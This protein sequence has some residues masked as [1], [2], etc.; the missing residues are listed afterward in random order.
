MVRFAKRKAKKILM[1]ARSLHSGTVLAF[2][3]ESCHVLTMDPT[4]IATIV[5]VGLSAACAVSAALSARRAASFDVTR[6]FDALVGV[7]AKL[8]KATRSETMSKVRAAALEPKH[9]PENTATAPLTKDQL[10]QL[11][12]ARNGGLTQ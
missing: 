10:R 11:V 6:D 5:L 4:L 7:V 12:R 3:H 1:L 8:Q 2:R 9:P